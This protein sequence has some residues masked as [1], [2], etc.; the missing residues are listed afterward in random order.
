MTPHTRE[1]TQAWL[2]SGQH[3]DATFWVAT[4]DFYRLNQKHI[5][6]GMRLHADLPIGPSIVR[7]QLV[8]DN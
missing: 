3:I 1:E 6:D 8:K 4:E 5:P 7:L 2:D